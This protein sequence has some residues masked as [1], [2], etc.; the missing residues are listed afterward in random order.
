[1]AASLTAQERA[2]EIAKAYWGRRGNWETS[3]ATSIT[4]ALDAHADAHVESVIEG[5]LL[6]MLP[7]NECCLQTLKDA[8]KTIRRLKSGKSGA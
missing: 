7:N 6:R 1:M 5:V 8:S 3:L 4:E 2:A